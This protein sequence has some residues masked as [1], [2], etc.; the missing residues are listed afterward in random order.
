MLLTMQYW[1]IKRSI[2]WHGADK[3]LHQITKF[4]K[5]FKYKYANILLVY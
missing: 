2:Q 4:L 1:T 3:I 5:I